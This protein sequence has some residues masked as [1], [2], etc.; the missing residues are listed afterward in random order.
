MKLK[1]K[2]DT[3]WDKSEW[4][5]ELTKYKSYIWFKSITFESLLN[6]VYYRCDHNKNVF[7]EQIRV[8]ALIY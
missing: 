2:T 8:Y 3:K 5:T 6:N 4:N 7:V 1:T